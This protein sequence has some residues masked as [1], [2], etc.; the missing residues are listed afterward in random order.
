MFFHFGAPERLGTIGQEAPNLAD[1][2]SK[3][4]IAVIDDKPFEPKDALITHK[5]RIV[6]LG[7]DIRSI[8]QVSTYPIIIC[9]VSG[10]AKAFGSP[11]EGAHL[12]SEIRKAYPDKFLMAYTGLTYSLAIT[13]ALIAADKRMEKDASSDAWVQN[14]EAGICEVVNPRSRWIRL[15]RAL[16]ER[17]VEL[18]DVLMLEQAFIKAVRQGKPDCLANA[19]RSLGISSEIRDLVIKFSATAVASLVG[20]ALGI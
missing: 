10:V 17:G 9:D 11:L 2:K 7:P 20:T 3:I 18:F 6:E 12:V 1:A 19:A 14:L 13:N 5:F 16:L 15:R 4:E 8:D